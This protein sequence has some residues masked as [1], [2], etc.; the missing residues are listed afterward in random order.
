MP[1]ANFTPT[2]EFTP[3]PSQP[4]AQP[5]NYM[6]TTYTD[7]KTPVVSLLAYV[8]GSAWSVVYYRQILGQHNDLKELDSTLSPEFQSYGRIDQMEL[9][10][11]QDLQSNTDNQTQNTKVEGSAMVYGFLIPNVNDYFTAD[12]SYRRGALFRVTN[13][14]RQTWKR[15]SVYLIQYVMVDYVDRLTQD[16]QS[17]ALKTTTVYVFSRDRLLEGLTPYLKTDTYAAVCELNNQRQ[18]IGERYIA[19]FSH[20]SAKTF[21]LPGQ[22]YKRIYDAFLVDFVMRTFGFLEFPQLLNVKQL[23]KDGDQYLEQ[24][25]FW[26]ALIEQDPVLLENGNHKMMTAS[27]DLFLR[28]S[29]LKTL[30]SSRCDAI[31]YPRLPDVSTMT[32]DDLTPVPVFNSTLRDTVNA[33]GVVLTDAQKSYTLL[34]E[35]VVAYHRVWSDDYY[36][37]T[38][39]FYVGDRPNMSLIELMVDDYLKAK[40]LDLKQIQFMVNLYPKMERMEQLYLGPILMLLIKY[41]DQRAY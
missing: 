41:A 22:P 20:H 16:M 25:Q 9:R 8:E 35:Q 31:V 7:R 23:P 28:N 6:G 34:D 4:V 27:S 14:N 32:G 13:V 36:V 2:T 15:E 11:V 3:T 40:T 1:I 17:L 30:Y 26:T 24:P 21:M 39:P 38:E 37:L 10:V 12:T 19:D 33:K 18:M 5:D 29:Y